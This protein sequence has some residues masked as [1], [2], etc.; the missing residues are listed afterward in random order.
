M[1]AIK[2]PRKGQLTPAEAE[3]FLREAHAA[4]HLTHANIV[5]VHEVG[6]EQDTVYIVSDLVHGANLDDWLADQL[7]DGERSSGALRKA[8]GSNRYGLAKVSEECWPK[9]PAI[10]KTS[11]FRNRPNW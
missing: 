5:A 4:A 8:G 10:G 7:A 3:Q 11:A 2:I 6:R 1:V 9:W